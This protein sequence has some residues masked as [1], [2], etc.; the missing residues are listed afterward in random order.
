M[1]QGVRF[2]GCYRGISPQ[3]TRQVRKTGVDSLAF[4]SVLSQSDHIKETI[5]QLRGE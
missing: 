3:N 4:I 2:C 5:E 1:G